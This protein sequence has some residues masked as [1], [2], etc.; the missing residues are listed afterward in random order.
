MTVSNLNVSV[1]H[2][3][4][5]IATSF[6]YTFRIPDP[7]YVVVEL[8]DY[9]TG[10]IVDTLTAGEYSITGTTV[11]NYSGGSVTYNPGTPLSSDYNIVI[12]RELPL[13]QTLDL[14]NQGGF[15]PESLEYQLDRQVMQIQQLKAELDAFDVNAD[16]FGI[17]GDGVTD[18]TAR[19]QAACDTISLRGGGALF[20]GEASKTI[21][22]SD[23]I[24]LG[25]NIELTG[26][27]T[28]KADAANWSGGALSPMFKNDNYDA[29]SIADEG[30]AFTGL[31]I[32]GDNYTTGGGNHA[33]R[34]RMV[35]KVRCRDVT[36][37]NVENGTAFLACEDTWTDAC[38]ARNIANCGFDHWDGSRG[39]KVTDCLVEDVAAQ[40]IQFTGTGTAAEDRDSEDFVCTGCTV[41]RATSGGNSASG[42]LVN[43]NDA[44]SRI[45]RVRIAHNYVADSDIAYA[46]TGDGAIG[47]F[48]GNIAEGCSN[49]AFLTAA[50]GDGYPNQISLVGHIAIDCATLV[51]GVIRIGGGSGHSVEGCIVKGPASYLYAVSMDG[52][53]DWTVNGGNLSAGSSG[54]VKIGAATAYKIDGCE[55]GVWTPELRFGGLTTG[56]AYTRR[57]GIYI[58]QGQHVRVIGE[59]LLSSSGSATGVASIGGLPFPGIQFGTGP[60][61]QASGI[62]AAYDAMVGLAGQGYPLGIIT[63]LSELYLYIYSSVTTGNLQHS[64]FSNTSRLRFEASY[65]VAAGK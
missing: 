43:A 41:R 34:L 2:R 65:I 53:D 24:V 16:E 35:R 55:F 3:G 46:M 42:I 8:Q 59:L 15:Y 49:T 30:I 20:L 29:V 58:K 45:G 5:G 61:N 39:V 64:Y 56:I 23:T 9:A 60:Q 21:L 37:V 18:D 57:S 11:D 62:V 44:G 63:A 13:T 51:E 48:V 17:V 22:I 26:R 38:T 1:T 19:L 33:I 12:R 28:V 27:A 25:S 54:T 4:D 6:P 52:A 32:D 40:G 7:A 36:F 31:T 47:S 10:L 14:L 50:N